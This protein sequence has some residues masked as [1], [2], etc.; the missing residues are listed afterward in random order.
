M[1]EQGI[2]ITQGSGASSVA[3]DLIGGLNYQQIKVVDATI[4]STNALKVNADGSIGASIIGMVPVNIV[5]GGTTGSVS[6]TVGASIIGQLPAGNAVIGAVAAS[7]SGIVNTAGSVFAVVSG[8]QGASVSGTVNAI[9]TN[10]GSIIAVSQGSIATVIIGGSIAASFT[11]PANQSVSGIV[12]ASLI[13]VGFSNQGDD[14]SSLTQIAVTGYSRVYNGSNWDRWRGNSSIGGLVNT[15]AGS[16][17]S[18]IQSSVA[19]VIIGGSIVASFIPPANQSV[20]GTVQTQV[21]ASVAVVII[22][23]SILTSS[24]ANQSVSGTVGASIIGQVPAKIYADAAINSFQQTI[25]SIS[26]TET[27]LN[28]A[29]FGYWF[30]GGTW[31]RARGNSSVGAFVSLN[32]NTIPATSS[33]LVGV[34]AN[35]NGSVLTTQGYPQAIVQVTSGPGASITGQVN[36]EGTVDGVQFVPIQGYN[37]STQAIAS[38]TG[39]ESDWA[40]NTAGLQG[41]RTRVSNWTVGSITAIA[42][43]SPSDAR[44]FSHTIVGTPSV[45]GAVNVSGS[46]VAFQGAGWS[47]SVAAIT[48]GQSGTVVTSVVGSVSVIG[49]VSVVG[50][51]GASIIG[52]VPTYLA[53]SNTAGAGQEGSNQLGISAGAA[54][55]SSTAPTG[56]A[57][58]IYNGTTWDR[59][60]GNSVAGTLVTPYALTSS[61]VSGVTSVMTGT[62]SVL[63]LAAPTG[64]D[65]NYVTQALVTNA[66][67]VGTTVSIVDNGN[68]IYTGFAAASGGGFAAN[69]P[70]PLRQPT[71]ALGLYVVSSIQASVYV[72]MTGFKAT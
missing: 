72:S 26:T 58:Y 57:N 36:F 27:G 44:Q 34:T 16:T 60:K 50:T 53:I 12:G 47:G 33:I 39:I 63:I 59:L 29:S 52:A 66:A 3:S 49:T 48:T 40:F 32:Q 61:L 13:G 24:T 45:S 68:I 28:T 46:V 22:G 11:P 9:S 17:I 55:L 23:G 25:D 65:R 38:A 5:S 30:N 1:S 7:I 31:D 64:N 19:T 8:L 41:I 51:I 37:I 71:S 14:G 35:T 4:G 70:A 67:A 54:N 6:G 62:T 69:L 42:K 15:G 21:Q 18:L 20:S 43:V 2:P 10:V 56:T